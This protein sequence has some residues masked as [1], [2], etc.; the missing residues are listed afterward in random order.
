MGQKPVEDSYQATKQRASNPRTMYTGSA[1]RS[2]SVLPPT[3]SSVASCA[4]RCWTAQP[5]QLHGTR[6]WSS[7]KNA[8]C[9]LLS[10]SMSDSCVRSPA[11]AKAPASCRLAGAL[12][13]TISGLLRRS[14]R[15]TGIKAMACSMPAPKAHDFW[16]ADSR[17]AEQRVS[18]PHAGGEL[19]G[20]RGQQQRYRSPRRTQFAHLPNRCRAAEQTIAATPCAAASAAVQAA[21]P[22]SALAATGQ[23]NR[24]NALLCTRPQMC[25]QHGLGL[26]HRLCQTK[27]R[28]RARCMPGIETTPRMASV[29]GGMQRRR[30]RPRGTPPGSL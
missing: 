4:S 28:T 22:Q 8:Q 20:A 9:V 11:A 23:D 5:G 17:H 21:Q 10:S 14:R 1:E 27:P 24:S 6:R 12:T 26:Q 18:T 16:G 29:C 3:Q 30:R 25:A 2:R 19:A 13:A 7:Q 15:T